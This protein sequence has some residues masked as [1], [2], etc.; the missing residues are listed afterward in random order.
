MVLTDDEAD[1]KWEES[2]DNYIEE[3]IQP[4]IDKLDSLG[5]LQY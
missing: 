5:N 4:E 2:L 3:C 1:E